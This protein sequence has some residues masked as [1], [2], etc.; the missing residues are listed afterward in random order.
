LKRPYEG[1]GVSNGAALFACSF[2]GHAS[3]SNGNSADES[4]CRDSLTPYRA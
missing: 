3:D 1:G 2:F 4:G